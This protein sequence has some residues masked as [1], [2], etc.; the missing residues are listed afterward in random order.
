MRSRLNARLAVLALPVA[1]VF[2]VSFLLGRYPVQPLDVVKVFASLVFPI[3][4]DWSATIDVVVLQIR[5]PRIVLGLCVGAALSVAGASFQGMFRNPLV[6]PDILGVSAAA[7]F[8]AALAILIS[9]NDLVIQLSATTFGM[10]GVLLSYRLGRVHGSSPVIMLVLG[11]VIVGSLFGALTSVTKYM[12][13]PESKLPAI[14]FWLLGSLGDASWQKVAT[15]TPPIV[16]GTTVLLVVGWRIN[17]LAMGDEE[18]LA[19]GVRT[20]LLKAVVIVAAT[21][22]TSAA[23]SVSGL[24]GWVGLVIPHASR[25]IVGPDHRRLLPASVLLGAAFLLG[26]DDIARTVTA[27][28]IP[29]GILTALIGTP[30]FAYLLRKTKGGW[31]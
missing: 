19:L 13:D 9:G 30:F 2:F 11:G 24:I 7:G 15:V 12:A 16:A 27:A 31:Q 5:L 23:V 22:V 28:E 3:R 8:G 1:L 21:L 4:H 14:T 10:L 29:L 20:E 26:I 25:M 18:A 17:L 6:S